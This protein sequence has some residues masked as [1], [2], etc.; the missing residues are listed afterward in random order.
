MTLFRRKKNYF[1]NFCLQLIKYR[2]SNKICKCS[3]KF[4]VSYKYMI[5]IYC[6]YTQI[7]VFQKLNRLVELV[8]Q[9]TENRE[10]EF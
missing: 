6:L 5:L 4:L 3:K 9:R 8:E 10:A 7:A 1:L 2:I